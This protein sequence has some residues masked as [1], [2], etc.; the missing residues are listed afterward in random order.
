MQQSGD[1]GKDFIEEAKSELVSRLVSRQW[2]N[3]PGRGSGM[4]RGMT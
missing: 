1:A 4:C 3:S 2:K